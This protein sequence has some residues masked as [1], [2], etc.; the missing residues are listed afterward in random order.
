MDANS[1]SKL[2]PEIEN[3][4]RNRGQ[5]LDFETKSEIEFLASISRGKNLDFGFRP[6]IESISGRN[7]KS[8][9]RVH[10]VFDTLNQKV[11]QDPGP[12]LDHFFTPGFVAEVPSDTI[13]T[14]EI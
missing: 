6:E 11:Y 4:A 3:L 7:P 5:K 10:S 1:I 13:C 14:S 2:R 8:R 9:F 12:L